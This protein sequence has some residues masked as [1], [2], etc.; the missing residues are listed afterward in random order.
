MYNPNFPI[1][2]HSKLSE[3][4]IMYRTKKYIKFKLKNLDGNNTQKKIYICRSLYAKKRERVKGRF[5]KKIKNTHEQSTLVPDLVDSL[6]SSLRYER[7]KVKFIRSFRIIPIQPQ[8]T[9]NPDYDDFVNK[10]G[11]LY[12]SIL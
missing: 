4:I 6:Q 9:N 10:Y 2:Y 8:I 7:E 11:K 1:L 12:Y 5:T 3:N